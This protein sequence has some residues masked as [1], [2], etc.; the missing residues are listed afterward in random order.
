M[1]GSC[2]LHVPR[3][4]VDSRAVRLRA[5]QPATVEAPVR[6]APARTGAK[7]GETIT[8]TVDDKAVDIVVTCEGT[9]AL[10]LVRED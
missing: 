6:G 10:T 5:D 9:C 3:S 8:V 7:S 2:T 4:T 1:D